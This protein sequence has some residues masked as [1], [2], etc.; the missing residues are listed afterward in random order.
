VIVF[1]VSR[2]TTENYEF[3]KNRTARVIGNAAIL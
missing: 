2:R 3:D 1:Y